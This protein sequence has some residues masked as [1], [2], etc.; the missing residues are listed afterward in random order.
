LEVT[1]A[2]EKPKDAKA[3]TEKPAP[4][5]PLNEMAQGLVDLEARV[6]VLEAKT[7]RPH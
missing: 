6:S 3:G 5:R 2:D 7:D 1:K 4:V